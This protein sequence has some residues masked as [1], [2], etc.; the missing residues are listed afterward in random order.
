LKKGFQQIDNKKYLFVECLLEVLMDTIIKLDIV[1]LLNGVQFIDITNNYFISILNNKNQIKQNKKQTEHDTITNLQLDIKELIKEH[2]YYK[3][4]KRYFSISIIE[5]KY[6]KRL[7]NLFNHDTGRFYKAV[8]SL[9][10]I[11][12]MTEQKFKSISTNIIKENLEMVK[13]FLS[14]VVQLKVEHILN[15]LIN[16]INLKSMKTINNKLKILIN[17]CQSYLNR[18]VKK[19]V[20][21]LKV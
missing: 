11:L 9:N 6:N 5:G 17:Y 20:D 21:E 12:L 1:Y 13:Q 19:Y 16:I 2:T 18:L 8:S 7:L 10:T 3:A 4:L 14:L 15:K